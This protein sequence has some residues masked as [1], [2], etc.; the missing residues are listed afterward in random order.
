M[1]PKLPSNLMN[2]VRFQVGCV[3]CVFA[4]LAVRA[5]AQT[6][7]LSP[8]GSSSM[9]TFGGDPDSYGFI[10]IPS[11]T[12]DWTRH[13]RIGAMVGMNIS[14]NFS[15][16]GNFK[17]PTKDGV[18]DDGY[19]HPDQSGDPNNTSNWGYD[20][21][22][23]YNAAADTISMHQITSYTPGTGG[24]SKEDGGAFP[25]FDMAYGD[26]LWYWKHARVGWELG[27]GL[28]PISIKNSFSSTTAMVSQSTSVFG[29]NGIVVPTA[30]YRG[31][32]SGVGPIIS[33]KPTTG[34]PDMLDNQLVTGTRTL[35]VMLYTFRL[36]PSFY[37]DLTEDFGMSLG[38]GPAIGI[39]SETLEY[40]ET[41]TTS[42][43]MARNRGSING[44]DVVFGGYINGTLTYHVLSNADIYLGAQYMPLGNASVSG[45][46]R[47]AEL[48]LGGQVDV[49]IGINWPF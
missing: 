12:D 41:V 16:K 3:A 36:G 44:T 47:Q 10:K 9:D 21:A 1:M 18:F 34:A 17:I 46:G 15:E 28:L 48:K 42:E 11:D 14:A 19:V 2:A 13:F 49:S 38:A 5:S 45:G 32:P 4:G 27:F 33:T 25:G 20:K 37:W 31:G 6:D 7:F 22:S 26:N 23:Q 40:D 24:S 43:G 8:G 29:A 39:A 30:P 35:N